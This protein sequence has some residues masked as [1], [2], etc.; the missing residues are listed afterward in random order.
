VVVVPGVAVFPGVAAGSGV[1]VI[2]GLEN[3]TAEGASMG[4]VAEGSA[5]SIN[6]NVAPAAS[7]K[8]AMAR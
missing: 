6:V 3:G 8:G 4:G 7:P 2:R 5:G 1:A